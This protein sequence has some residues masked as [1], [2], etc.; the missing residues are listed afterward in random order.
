MDEEN[1]PDQTPAPAPEVPAEPAPVQAP[2]SPVPAVEAPPPKKRS[3]IK[4][5]LLVVVLLAAVCAAAYLTLSIDITDPR[6]GVSY[7]Y[8]TTYNVWFPDG[9]PVTIGNARMMSLSYDDELIFD[10]NG[11]REKLVVGEEKEIGSHEAIVKV[12][13]VTVID[14]DFRMLLK[15]RGLSEGK[16]NF[17]LTVQTSRQIPQ[18]LVDRLLPKEIQAQPA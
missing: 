7:P 9:E 4:M 11:N 12:F 3:G 13:G 10:V 16:A 17:Y 15:Y 1:V 18:F 6:Q 8:T 14:T 2:P 5:V